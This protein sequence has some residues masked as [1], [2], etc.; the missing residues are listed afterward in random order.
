MDST[1]SGEPCELLAWDSEFWGFSVARVLGTCLTDERSRAIDRWCRHN[2]V[3]CLYFLGRP[4]DAVMT[5]SAERNGYHLVDIRME[6]T[7][8]R[9]SEAQWSRAMAQNDV[10]VRS[11]VEAD[12]PALEQIAGESYSD[13]RF[14]FDERFPRPLCDRLY[15]TWIERSCHG[16]ADAVLVAERAAK[17]LG[18]VSCHLD[19]GTAT[20][21]V[22]LVGVLSDARGSGIGQRLISSALVWF[23][24]RQM[25]EVRVVTQGRNVAAQRLYQ[26]AGF[27]TASLLLSYHK[28]FRAAAPA[29]TIGGKDQ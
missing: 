15:E 3:R 9:P 19:R 22:G 16:A 8:G 4:A 24:A 17:I 6:L 12:I 5:A 10:R 25:D 13:S 29:A 28:W 23:A 7:C 21:R 11:R 1:Y 27:R 2:G 26:A 18:Y 14:Y 20:G